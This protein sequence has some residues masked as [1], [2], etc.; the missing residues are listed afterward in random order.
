MTETATITRN[1][2]LDSREEAIGLCG[3][4]DQYLRMIRDAIGVR[5]VARGDLLQLDGTDEQVNQAERVFQ[6]LRTIL[7]KHSRVNPDDVK[8]VLEV[9]DRKSVV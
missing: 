3:V 2:T 7:R 4:R 8:S 1:L 5:I 6:Q 9:I